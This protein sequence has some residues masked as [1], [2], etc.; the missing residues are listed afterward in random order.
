MNSLEIT[1]LVLACLIVGTFFFGW[2]GF[3]ILVLLAVL[4]LGLWLKS[5]MPAS[6]ADEREK[7]KLKAEI[8]EAEKMFL[9]NRIDEKTFREVSEKNN[10]RLI[11]L[12]AKGI[13]GPLGFGLEGLGL[14]SKGRHILMQAL[15]KKAGIERELGLAEK[16][17]L[18]R[19]IDDKTYKAIADPKKKELISANAEVTQIY[20]ER[21]REI[22]RESVLRA[23]NRALKERVEKRRLAEDVGRQLEEEEE[24]KGEK[25]Q[26]GKARERH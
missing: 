1:A 25:A 4:G 6:R 26:R 11:E 10:A 3:L 8:D 2:A 9:K 23:K 22:A 18:K 19:K 13:E 15:Q 21:A 24:G 7:E 12:R 17:F 20:K 5:N 16:D 14:S